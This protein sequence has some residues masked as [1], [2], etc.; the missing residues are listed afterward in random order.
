MLKLERLFERAGLPV[1]GL[2]PALAALY[3][4]DFGVAR[5]A[6]YANFVSSIDGVVALATGAESGQLISGGSE[7]D[8]FVM[9]LLRAVA[10]AVLARSGTLT[11]SIRR[12][13]TSSQSC[14]ASWG[15]ARIRCWSWPARRA[16]STRA[17]RR[18]R[19][20]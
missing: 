15:C 7:P 8:R 9:G 3:G 2:P 14:G 17:I 16:T 6:L 4:G 18:S 13:A 12:P 1:A 11:A 20:R 5:P 19:T 10:D